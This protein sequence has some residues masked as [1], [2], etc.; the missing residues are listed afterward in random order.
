MCANPMVPSMLDI[1]PAARSYLGVPFYH[2]GRDR[3]G[4]DCIGLIV[5][6]AKDLGYQ[7]KDD[8]NY[9]PGIYPDRMLTGMSQFSHEVDDR[10]PGDILVFGHRGLPMHCAIYTGETIIHCEARAWL[11]KVVET[12]LGRYAKRIHSV[13]RFN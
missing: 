10:Q 12:S 13:W 6:V 8:R 3:K 7:F 4:I 11:Q 5:C 1:I 9:A 2:A